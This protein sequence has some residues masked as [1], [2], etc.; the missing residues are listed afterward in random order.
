MVE[1]VDKGR[2]N[3]H[4]KYQREDVRPPQPTALLSRVFVQPLTVIAVLQ[5]ILSFSFLAV[6]HVQHHEERRAG[7]EDEL[8]RPQ[9]YVGHRKEVV[10]TNVVA[11]GLS[12]VTREVLLIVAPHLLGGNDEDHDSEEEDYGEPHAAE[13]GGVLVD[14]AE[15]TLKKSPIHGDCELS[16]CLT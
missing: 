12:R 13:R 5:T 4:L 3:A 7:D 6:G 9:A 10:V 15:E 2:I 1:Q 16:G 14:P 11:A 8:Q